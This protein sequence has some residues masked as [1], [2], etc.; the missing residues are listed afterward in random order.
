MHIHVGPQTLAA[1][2]QM[3]KDRHGIG[4]CR[5]H[6]VFVWPHT[7]GGAIVEHHAIF[8]QHQ[9]IANLAGGKRGKSV[10]INPVKECAR[11]RAL[12]VDFAKG[13]NIADAH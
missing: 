5:R 1:V 10:G 13:R 12:D 8:A 2:F 11:I 4:G 9:P 6:D 3:A 7:G